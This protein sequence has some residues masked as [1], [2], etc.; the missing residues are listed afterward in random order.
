MYHLHHVSIFLL[1]AT[2]KISQG[3]GVGVFH[4]DTVGNHSSGGLEATPR[5]SQCHNISS[6][7]TE[8][9]HTNDSNELVCVCVYV[10]VCVCVC[11]CACVCV[12]DSHTSSFLG[13]YQWS[14]VSEDTHALLTK[15]MGIKIN[16]KS[17]QIQPHFIIPSHI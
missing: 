8:C 12:C 4:F 9:T 14:H 16:D 5:H 11:M 7:P 3:M 2:T 6:L 17:S 1:R 15:I 13:P 10:C